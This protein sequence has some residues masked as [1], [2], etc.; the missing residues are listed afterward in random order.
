MGKASPEE[1]RIAEIYGSMRYIRP[2]TMA[3]KMWRRSCRIEAQG[4]GRAEIP[5][6]ITGSLLRKAA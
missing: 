4:A 1:E 6:D 5:H 3:G 2:I